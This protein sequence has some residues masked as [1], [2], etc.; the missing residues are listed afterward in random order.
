MDRNARELSLL[1]QKIKT[2]E[3]ENAALREQHKA[4]TTSLPTV[5]S[6]DSFRPLFNDAEKTVREYFS[7]FHP[8]PSR[9]T[10]DISGERYLLVRASALSVEFLNSIKSLYRDRGEEEAYAIGRNFLFD[11]AHVIGKEDAKSFHSKMK[12]T[13]P[14]AKLSAGPV[15][16]AYTGWAFV[17]ILPES[18][19][20]PDEN[21]FLSYRHPYSFEAD[22]WINAKKKA[23]FPVCIMNAGYSSG[24][25][26][27]SFGVELTA[28]E[29]TC[30]AMGHE[31][32]TFIMAPPSR[33]Q[34]YLKT[35]KAFVHSKK[36]LRVPHFFERK[37][38]EE[39]L[40]ASVK[41]KELLL[42]EI[43][44]RVKNNLQI[45]SSLLSLQSMSITDKKL[46]QKFRES[47]DRIRSMALLH[48]ALYST[49]EFDNVSSRHYFRALTRSLYGSYGKSEKE[50]S[51]SVDIGKSSDRMT[52][53]AAIPCGLIINELISNSLKYAFP[54]G[55]QGSIYVKLNAKGHHP[56]KYTLIIGDTGRGLPKRVLTGEPESLG[57]QLV[58]ALVEQLS[59]SV[60]IN[61]GNGAEFI[62]TFEA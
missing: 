4:F 21:Y 15:H 27:E 16:F 5:K 10:I 48:E 31:S 17:D 29:V 34:H 58:F 40:E 30:R 42:K 6:P 35:H 19:P 9:G 37:K 61:N 56:A 32:C 51:L 49:H 59:G 11:I 54:G 36:Q 60:I 2:L 41:E 14:I 26:E 18:R 24:W 45:I 46:K 50:I 62:I 47:Q 53:D 55:K 33:I 23:K 8:D 39:D 28:V 22:S 57:L 3:K 38:I 52:I 12:L 43:H 7:D 13:D 1:R 20:S 25:C 44:H